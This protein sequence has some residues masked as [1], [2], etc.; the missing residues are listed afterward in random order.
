MAL[1]VP[2]VLNDKNLETK[3]LSI[4]QWQMSHYWYKLSTFGLM[5]TLFTVIA[6]TLQ[7]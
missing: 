2:T 1:M 6:S 7:L 5:L 3:N 4:L